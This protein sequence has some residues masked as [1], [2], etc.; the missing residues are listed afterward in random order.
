MDVDELRVDANAVLIALHRTFEDV[1]DAK[2]LADLL[3]VD[4]P[5]LVS[6]SGVAGDDEL[7]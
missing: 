7:P 3:G 5:A 2:L 4:I 1:S 6:E